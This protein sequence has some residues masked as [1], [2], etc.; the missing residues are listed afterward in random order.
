MRRLL[1]LIAALVAVPAGTAHAGAFLG[2]AIDGPSPDVESLGDLDLARDGSGALTYL[3]RVDGVDHV[4]VARFTGGAF[5][6]GERID[7]GLTPAS[8]Q[9]VV[10][11]ADGEGLVVVFVNGGTVYGVVRPAGQSFAAPVALGTGSDPS[12]DLSINGTAYASYTSGGDVR[13]AR[14]DRQTNAWAVLPQAAD[15]DPAR[16]AG[17]GSGRARVAISADGVGVVTWGEAGHVYARKMFGASLSG[18]PQ[19]LTPPVFEDR[20]SATSDLPDIDAEDDSSYAWVVFRQTFVD[21]SSRILARRQRGT[22]FDPPVAVEA[23]GGGP[24]AEPNL[25]MNGR[26]VG[27]ATTSGATSGQ[28]MAD[29]L[30]RDAF[31][32]GTPIFGLS[33][34]AIPTAPAMSENNDGFV[35][36]VIGAA[37]TAPSAQLLPYD[38]LKPGVPVVISRPELGAVDPARGFDAAADRASGGVVAWVQGGAADRR[39]VAGYIDRPPDRFRGYTSASCCQPALANLTWQP[40]FNLWGVHRYQVRV[41]GQLVGE[42]EDTKLRL[43]V[44]LAG[45]IHHWQVT[46]VDPRGQTRRSRTRLLRIDDLVPRLSVRYKRSKRIVVISARGRDLG[47]TGHRSSGIRDVAVAWGDGSGGARGTSRLRVRHRYGG[48]GEFALEVTARDRAGNVSVYKRTVRI[49]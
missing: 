29:V 19:D 11:A 48:T 15:V 24:V 23:P 22:G 2:D 9:P 30:D 1:I 43:T 38:D 4:F 6:P 10:G 42:T 33:A 37:G 46:A 35:A 41:D 26:G 31:A 5:G 7:P 45:A 39:I 28:P 40:S 17:A 34:P 20:A 36:S 8:S 32:V 21:G 25:E 14:L 3:K 18:A 27:L 44:P 16:P 13:I 47:G 12:V 49:G